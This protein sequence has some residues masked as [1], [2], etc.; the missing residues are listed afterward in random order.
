MKNLVYLLFLALVGFG[1]AGY[2][3]NWYKFTDDKNITGHRQ[4]S[5]DIDTNKVGEDLRKGEAKVGETLQNLNQ[6]NQAG[7]GNVK[8]TAADQ[9]PSG[10]P[11]LQTPK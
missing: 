7:A 9:K 3:L 11:Q 4:L 5:I 1:V 2:F 6:E 8:P 10:P